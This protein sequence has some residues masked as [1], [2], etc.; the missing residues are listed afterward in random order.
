MRLKISLGLQDDALLAESVAKA[1]AADVA[2]AGAAPL[3]P[4]VKK[5]Q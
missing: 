3:A 4:G 5:D 2:D 1:V